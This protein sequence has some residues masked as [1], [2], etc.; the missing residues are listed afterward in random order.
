MSKSPDAFRTITEVAEW[1]GI[2]AHVLRFWESKFNQ[3][4]PVKRAGGRRYY[5]PADMLLVGGIKTLLHDDGLTIKGVQ[6]IIK[7]QGITHVSSLSQSLD[8][9]A[10]TILLDGAATHEDTVV[11]F[12]RAAAD[13]AE[14]EPDIDEAISARATEVA[15]AIAPEEE[16]PEPRVEEPDSPANP[17]AMAEPEAPSAPEAAD[18]IPAPQIPRI[19]IPDPLPADQITVSPG[20]LTRLTNP[21]AI[22]SSHIAELS[23]AREQLAALCARLGNVTSD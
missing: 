1:L 8:D 4:K 2:Q 23:E 6:K 11:S 17:P 22:H 18:P 9:H 12:T 21:G 14:P 10:E 15:P 20:A 16:T 3:V 13:S 5:R 19:D 7:E